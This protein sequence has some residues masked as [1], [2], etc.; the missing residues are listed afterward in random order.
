MYGEV[1]L[2]RHAKPKR[3]VSK[4]GCVKGMQR[5]RNAG[6]ARNTFRTRYDHFEYLIMLFDL[7]NVSTTFQ[8]YINKSL[9]SL[10]NNFYVIYLNDIL[11]YSSSQEEHLNHIKQVLKRLR[12]FS[13]YISLKKCEFFI[14]E[15]EFLDFI[16]FIDNVAMNKRRVKAIQK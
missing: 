1:N 10:I 9:T 13:L 4:E 6:Y 5:R 16:M 14:T 2:P 12:R 8:T 7:I 11:I 3:E 15:V